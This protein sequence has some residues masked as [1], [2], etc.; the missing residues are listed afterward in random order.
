MLRSVQNMVH[1]PW[2]SSYRYLAA[3]AAAA[4]EIRI[5]LYII[6]QRRPLGVVGELY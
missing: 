1:L 2:Q 3:A 4:S 5:V 6:R